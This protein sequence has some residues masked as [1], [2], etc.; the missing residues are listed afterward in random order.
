MFFD[1]A[2]GKKKL[3]VW[4][5]N[6]ESQKRELLDVNGFHFIANSQ[7]LVAHGDDNIVR[8]LDL[9][10]GATD[11]LRG[12]DSSVSAVASSRQGRWLATGANDGSVRAGS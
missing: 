9:P 8:L 6:D 1:A 12:H 7:W 5:L 4:S 10:S 2:L 11:S 3:A